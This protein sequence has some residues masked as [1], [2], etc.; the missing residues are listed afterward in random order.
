MSNSLSFIPLNLEDCSHLRWITLWL[1]IFGYFFDVCCTEFCSD[2]S[3]S[4][5][6]ITMDSSILCLWSCR[7]LC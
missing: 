2:V 7:W 6:A 3:W 1:L 4:G 5:C